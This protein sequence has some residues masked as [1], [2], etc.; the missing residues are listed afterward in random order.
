MPPLEMCLPQGAAVSV[1][2][3]QDFDEKMQFS[4]QTQHMGLFF[5]GKKGDI[6]VIALQNIKTFGEVFKVGHE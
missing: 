2:R 5:F 3:H 6:L 4:L 1:P